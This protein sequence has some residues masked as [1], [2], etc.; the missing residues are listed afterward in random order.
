M[1][2]LRALER[3]NVTR[4]VTRILD[5]KYGIDGLPSFELV[6]ISTGGPHRQPV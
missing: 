6:S 3:G 1:F 5:K 2:L 4:F